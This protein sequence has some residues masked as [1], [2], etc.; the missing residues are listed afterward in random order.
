MCDTNVAS[1]RILFREELLRELFIHNSHR[2]GAG[3][4]GNREFAALA[5]RNLRG[6]KITGAHREVS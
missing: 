2:N 4:I 1:H 5:Q 3:V 6:V